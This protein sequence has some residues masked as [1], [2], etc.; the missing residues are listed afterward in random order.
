MRY[1]FLMALAIH[2]MSVFAAQKTNANH[3]VKAESTA[4]RAPASVDTR[5]AARS[6]DATVTPA[7]H[8]EV[9]SMLGEMQSALEKSDNA[10][11]ANPD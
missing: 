5:S 7:P 8:G 2:S 9:D 6:T 10:M 1:V 3:S 11:D 4:T